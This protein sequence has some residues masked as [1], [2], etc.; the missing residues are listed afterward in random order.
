MSLLSDLLG[1]GG[2]VYAGKEI[3]DATKSAADTT[4]QAQRDINQNTLDFV[5]KGAVDSYGNVINR[6]DP[7]TGALTTTLTG[8]FKDLANQNLAAGTKASDAKVG[9]GDVAKRSVSDF[10]GFTGAGGRPDFSRADAQ[11]I[12]GADDQRIMNSLVNPALR[13]AA[14]T[15]KRTLGGT[16]GAGNIVAKTMKEIQPQVKLGGETRALELKRAMDDQF[17]KN[18]LGISD[19]A[20][21]QIAAPGLVSVPGVANAG[22]TSAL[23]Q[24]LRVPVPTTSPDLGSAALLQG[25]QGLGQSIKRNEQEQ[26]A[27]TRYQDAVKFQSD[28]LDTL[29]A[30]QRLK[31]N[32]VVPKYNPYDY[33]TTI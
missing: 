27:E 28:L 31:A 32:E 14:I 7:N 17:V 33:G 16:S 3:A 30:Q 11:N 18:T 10:S 24:A 12:V 21:K 2:T 8:Q 15:D 5:A 6:R 23:A 29:T 20:L 9:L 22:E 4:A 1:L 25:V 19:N 26:L 13:D